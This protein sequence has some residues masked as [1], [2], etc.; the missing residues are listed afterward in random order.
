MCHFIDTAFLYR[1]TDLACF[2]NLC[3]EAPDTRSRAPSLAIRRAG[4]W[5]NV[6]LSRALGLHLHDWKFRLC[7]QYWLGLCMAEEGIRCPVCQTLAGSLE[8]IKLDVGGIMTY[9]T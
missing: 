6:K 1:T 2:D 5:L 3:S 8:A 4:D 9:V 7:L